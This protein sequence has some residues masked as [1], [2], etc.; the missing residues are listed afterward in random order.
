M[1]ELSC[2]DSVPELG[3]ALYEKK[4]ERPSQRSN[5]QLLKAGGVSIAMQ[6]NESKKDC[7]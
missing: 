6:L 2:S 7:E 4:K 5:Q 1:L 3:I